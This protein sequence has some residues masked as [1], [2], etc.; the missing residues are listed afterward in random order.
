MAAPPEESRKFPDSSRCLAGGE[1]VWREGYNLYVKS[2][3]LLALPEDWTNDA[4]GQFFEDFVAELLG[5]LRFKVVQRLRFTGMEI[6]LLAK[7]LDQP[8]TIVVE[9]KAHRDPLPADVISK[10]LGN[11]QIRRADAG[12][13]FTTSDLNKDGRAQWEDIQANPDLLSRFYWYS[14]ERIRDFLIDQKAVV[15]PDDLRLGSAVAGDATL[16]VSPGGRHWIVELLQEGIPA[17]FAA[18]DARTGAPLQQEQA[19]RIAQVST[20]FASLPAAQPQDPDATRLT[21]YVERATVA[22]VISGDRWDDLRPSR[23]SDFVGRDE[24][25]RDI[26]EFIRGVVERQTATRSFAVHGPSGWGK[27]SLV[28]K[29]TSMST[30]G[31]IANCST[32]SID[33]RSA[34]NS[35]FVAEALRTAFVE[36]RKRGFLPD[37]MSITIDSIAY[38]LDSRDVAE[39]LSELDRR[40]SAILLIFDQFEELFAKE[41]LFETFRAVRELALDIDAK[42]VPIILA[43][44]WKTDIALPQ[45]HPA[46]HLWHEL[47]D[48]R[49]TFQ[50]REFG[51]GEVAKV[52]TKVEKAVGT[53]LSAAVRL[54]LVE[55]CQG[56]PWLLKKL[57][58]HIFTRLSD[59]ESQF[60]LLERELDIEELFKHDLSMLSEDQV[61][62]LKY[63]AT[64]APIAV[65]EVEANFSRETTNSLI[66]T[67]LL[68][69]SGMNYVVYWDIFRDYLVDGK[70]PNIPWARTFHGDPNTALRII[71]A[72]AELGETSVP[73]IAA[74]I[75]VREGPTQNSLS[76]AVALQLVD[77]V[78][79]DHYALAPHIA[80]DDVQ[81]VALHVQ[82][83]L[84]RHRV[85]RELTKHWEAGAAFNLA[86]WEKFF[87]RAQPRATTFSNKTLQMYSTRFR[88]W[89]LFSGLVDTTERGLKRT[90]G[91]ARTL[92]RLRS[93]SPLHGM[94]LGASSPE[95]VQ[96]LLTLL[97]SGD[98]LTRREI[99]RQ[100]LRNALADAFALGLL[101]RSEGGGISLLTPAASGEDRQAHLRNAVLISPAAAVLD[102]IPLEHLS[103]SSRVATALTESLER[104]D[105]SAASA[106]RNSRGLLR[107]YCWAKGYRRRRR[108]RTTEF[109]P[110]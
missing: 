98:K 34:V 106:Y 88:R 100:Q 21:N 45:E 51:K 59:Q 38:P 14:P 64:N 55:Q 25:L 56:L 89:L 36:A 68:V 65:S 19:R 5:P 8:R 50:I 6:D 13:L 90:T 30:R 62:C 44:A 16:V 69:R 108:S 87:V 46:Y 75:G 11:I 27:S 101:A 93:R 31:Q 53:K 28:L 42:Q 70:V 33:S 47:A 73:Q 60:A 78:G 7:S 1:Y 82:G 105:W 72:V 26:T 97:A 104:S 12:W 96:R 94:F 95:A 49:R 57:L 9:C 23:P 67:R 110:N 102:R 107:F 43:F 15:S 103:D 20:R 76:D 32:T 48:R 91:D 80:A 29:V 79:G 66:N 54:R 86:D 24:L 85:Y 35:A 17:L 22:P 83:Q 81:K 52:I 71:S 61:R 58:V 63:V 39:A 92:G 37:N 109:P 4:K 3:I 74:H 10:L 41:E 2:H 84:K 40:G 99:E 77:R 18:F